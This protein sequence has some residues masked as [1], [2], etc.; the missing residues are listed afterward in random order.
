MRQAA[1][2]A[3]AYRH[4]RYAQSVKANVLLFDNKMERKDKSL[5]DLKNLPESDDLAE[6][7]IENIEAGLNSFR[8]ILKGIA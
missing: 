4:L 6:E 5:A 3:P 8:E 7:I 1:R 2:T